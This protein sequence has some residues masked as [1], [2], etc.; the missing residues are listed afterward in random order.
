MMH[1]LWQD[2][3]FGLRVL[4]KNPGFTINPFSLTPTHENMNFLY[5]FLRFEFDD[6]PNA[7]LSC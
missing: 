6:N 1:P 7:N 3:R 2:I 4:A 5:L